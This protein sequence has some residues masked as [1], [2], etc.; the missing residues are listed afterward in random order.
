MK[1]C[2]HVTNA[3]RICYTICMDQQEPQEKASAEAQEPQL[4]TPIAHAV[5]N[6]FERKEPLNHEPKINVNRFLSEIATWYEKLRNAMDLNDDEVIL[7]SAI[8]RILKRRLLLG[9]DG[10]RV[11]EPLIRELI[12]AHYFPNNTLP[13]STVEKVMEIVDVYLALRHNAIDAGMS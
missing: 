4:L 1:Q 3:S 10:K 12:W 6:V 9:G 7:R 5:V 8:E 2:S 11:A 13:E